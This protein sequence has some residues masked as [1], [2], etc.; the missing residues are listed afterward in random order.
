MTSFI[1][2]EDY[3]KNS[4]KDYAI[5]GEVV[6][7]RK[8]GRLINFPTANILQST[9]CPIPIPGVYAVRVIQ[10]NRVFFG[11][12]NVGNKPTF[13]D[14][15]IT[16]EVHIF[17]FQSEIYGEEIEV[18]FLKRMRNQLK[19]NSVEELKEQLKED[20]KNVLLYLNTM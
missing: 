11:M 7:G 13:N 1:N 3:K 10:N 9:T 8:I 16:M 14:E 5:K 18:H 17:D 4:K 2:I 12:M 15:S 6:H 19:F 20:E